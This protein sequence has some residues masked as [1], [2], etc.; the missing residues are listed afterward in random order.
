[1]D[2]RTPRQK[3]LAIRRETIRRLDSLTDDQLRAAAGGAPTAGRTKTTRSAI[4]DADADLY[5]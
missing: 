5:C 2:R 3:K 4:M 1:M